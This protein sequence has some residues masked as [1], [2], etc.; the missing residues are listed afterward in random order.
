[1]LDVTV[2]DGDKEHEEEKLIPDY[3]EEGNYIRHK[4]QGND[5]TNF[6][7][8]LIMAKIYQRSTIYT[9]SKVLWCNV[10]QGISWQNFLFYCNN[11]FI[12]N[13][14]L[15]TYNLALWIIWYVSTG[16]GLNQFVILY[17]L[18]TGA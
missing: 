9:S 15:K 6:S 8:L 13:I 7:I 18:H 16:H 3:D 2:K 5:D 14:M 12:V 1:M 17:S 10:S 11:S 4:M